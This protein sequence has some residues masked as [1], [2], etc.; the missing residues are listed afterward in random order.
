LTAKTRAVASAARRSPGPAGVAPR[1][2]G[3]VTRST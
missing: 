2:I 3:A 1:S